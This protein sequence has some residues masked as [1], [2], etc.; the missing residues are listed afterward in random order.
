MINWFSCCFQISLILV[1]RKPDGKTTS[2]A[3]SSKRSG[4]TFTSSSRSRSRPAA[5]KPGPMVT[6]SGR[7]TSPT[8]LATMTRDQQLHFCIGTSWIG[9]RCLN[10]Q[11]LFKDCPDREANLESFG[12]SFIFS[13]S[14]QCLRPLCYC[15]HP[16]TR[17][18]T[19]DL[20][21]CHSISRT[22]STIDH[23]ATVPQLFYHLG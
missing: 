7:R 17:G 16:P 23:S 12:F 3:K 6:R 15:G 2:T 13:V 20:L 18:L 22:S 10:V 11:A 21:V 9:T 19:R 5:T 1:Q 4:K 8:K 14:K